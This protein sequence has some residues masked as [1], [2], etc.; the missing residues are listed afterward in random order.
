MLMISSINT[1]KYLQDKIR[2]AKILSMLNYTDIG[3]MVIDD[4]AHNY[5]E[6]SLD[7]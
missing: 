7:N 6:K 1:A 3:F 5:T 4:L 2:L